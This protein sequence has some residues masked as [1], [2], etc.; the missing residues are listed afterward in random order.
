MI[1]VCFNRRKIYLDQKPNLFFSDD[2]ND[3]DDDSVDF[4]SLNSS[5]NLRPKEEYRFATKINEALKTH[6]CARVCVS[7]KTKNNSS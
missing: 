5:S 7:S 6:R 3:D 1:S 2:D 4:I